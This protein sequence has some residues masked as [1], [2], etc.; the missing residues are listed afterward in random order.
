MA[1]DDARRDRVL[2]GTA[3]VVGVTCVV[4]GL[5]RLVGEGL[6]PGVLW[7][8]IVGVAAFAAFGIQRVRRARTA[9]GLLLVGAGVAAIFGT[10]WVEG[11]LRSQSIV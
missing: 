7:T 1:P 6:G 2:A 3:L 5:I 4:I 8:T 10:A 9:A 11:G